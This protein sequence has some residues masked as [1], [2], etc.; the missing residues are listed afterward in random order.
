MERG[1]RKPW[2]ESQVQGVEVA[3]GLVIEQTSAGRQTRSRK[4]FPAKSEG[5]DGDTVTVVN[6]K[7]VFDC[8]KVRGRWHKTKSEPI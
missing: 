2:D 8:R 4:S 7:G 3:D 1:N 5:R 6:S